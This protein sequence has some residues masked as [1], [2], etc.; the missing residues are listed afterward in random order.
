MDLVTASGSGLDPHI[1]VAAARI[2]AP[3]IARARGIPEA[4]VNALIDR[5]TRRSVVP[6]LGESVVPVLSINLAL[7]ANAAGK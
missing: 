6:F 1:S 4:A 3:R 7:D 5:Y 2:Q